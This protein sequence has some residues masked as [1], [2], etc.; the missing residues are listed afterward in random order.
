MANC[1]S[2]ASAINIIAGFPTISEWPIIH[3]LKTLHRQTGFLD[4]LTRRL[5][6]PYK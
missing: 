6:L 1:H 4:R 2:A 3:D 5:P